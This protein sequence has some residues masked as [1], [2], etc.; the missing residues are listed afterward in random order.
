ME[1][2]FGNLPTRPRSRESS[3]SQRSQRDPKESFFKREWRKCRKTVWQA[4]S[5]YNI[6]V[7]ALM[8]FVITLVILLVFRP[9]FIMSKNE[10]LVSQME[11][12]YLTDPQVPPPADTSEY[13]ISVAQCSCGAVLP[14]VPW[15]PRILPIVH[16]LPQR[17]V[18]P[19]NL[20]AKLSIHTVKGDVRV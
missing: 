3:E 16:L 7:T 17:S 13:T 2:R 14:Q 11:Y 1:A 8:S 9:I 10:S 6:I 20:L 5:M 15:I 12:E 18:S 19:S 4:G